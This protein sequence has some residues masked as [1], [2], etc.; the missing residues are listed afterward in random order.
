MRVSPVGVV[1]LSNVGGEGLADE[2]GH[3]GPRVM[4]RHRA[5]DRAKEAPALLVRTR[6]FHKEV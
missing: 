2:E 3:T 6:R 1:V 4:H 5:R